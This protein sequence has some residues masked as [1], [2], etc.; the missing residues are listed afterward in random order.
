[1]SPL[2]LLKPEDDDDEGQRDSGQQD[3]S[4]EPVRIDGDQEEGERE[5]DTEVSEPQQEEVDAEEP[6]SK[7]RDTATENRELR[8]RLARLEGQLTA[9]TPAREP[10]SR[11]PSDEEK[12]TW[13][14]QQHIQY[15]LQKSE[16][17]NQQTLS[18]I[19]FQTLEAGDKAGWA[20][21][22]AND[23]RA[24][25]LTNDV[26]ARLTQ[27]RQQGQWG[28]S[29]GDVYTRLVG[30]RAIAQGR[31]AAETQ[32]QEG[33]KRITKQTTRGASPAGDQRKSDRGNLTP[34]QERDKRLKDSGFFG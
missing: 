11:E 14:T 15:E 3:E 17:R 9:R 7:R 6:A 32:R 21:Y 26:E 29:R 12:A 34:Q 22:C 31:K 4:R 28:W 5:E 13:T 19:Q 20:S 24:R 2:Q 30:E 23:P 1:V 16:Q 10:A 33:A 27:L 25:K 8:E 18:Q